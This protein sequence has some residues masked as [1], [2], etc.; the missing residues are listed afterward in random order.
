[1]MLATRY[2]ALGSAYLL[3]WG[4]AGE[5]PEAE[6]LPPFLWRL[7]ASASLSELTL[8]A[9]AAL[10]I[11]V[12]EPSTEGA[13]QRLLSRSTYELPS[14]IIPRRDSSNATRAARSL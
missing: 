13:A 9:T 14:S 6:L 3:G 2:S 1:M 5:G 7:L 12:S 10:S 8:V 11:H 4:L